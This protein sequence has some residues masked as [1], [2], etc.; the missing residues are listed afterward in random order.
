MQRPK[1]MLEAPDAVDELDS[2]LEELEDLDD[3]LVELLDW[4]RKPGGTIGD[5]PHAAS[6]ST[7]A[8]SALR[9]SR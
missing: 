3:E 9:A 8:A 6:A 2:E 4:A 7:P 5:V 1:V